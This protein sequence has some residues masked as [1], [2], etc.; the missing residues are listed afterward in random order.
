MNKIS[1]NLTKIIG[2]ETCGLHPSF[3]NKFIRMKKY[4]VSLA[5]IFLFAASAVSQKYALVD[6][7]YI[8]NNIPSY[9]AA[10]DKIDEF[11]EEWQKKIEEK[12]EKIDKMYKDYRAEKV[13]LSDEMKKRKE[14]QIIQKEKELRELQKEYFGKEGKLFQKRQELIKPIQE[15]V[16]KAI[17]EMAE[18]HNIAVVFDSATGMNMLYTDPKYDRSDEVLEILGYKN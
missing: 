13:L 8:L 15:E 5:I 3:E 6:T 14:E 16:Y 7:D 11:S 1:K 10:E 12:K 4:V 18:K 2:F 9:K 17:K